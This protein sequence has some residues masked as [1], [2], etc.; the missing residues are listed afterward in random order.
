[1]FLVAFLAVV[2]AATIPF[3]PLYHV[4]WFLIFIV[5][6]VLWRRAAAGPWHHH[7]HGD[8]PSSVMDH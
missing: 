3:Y 4:P 7:H 1:M 2:A 5:G 8:R 6:F